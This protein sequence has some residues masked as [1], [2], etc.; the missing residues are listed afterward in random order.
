M[1][2]FLKEL[3]TFFEATT[4]HGL[5]YLSQ[6]HS[7]STRIIWTLIV[8]TAFG[9]ASYFLYETIKGFDTKYTSTTVED[10]S[11]HEYPFPA[12]T[13]DPNVYNSKIYFL[14]TF[15]NQFEFTAYKED[16]PKK[17]IN[18]QNNSIGLFLKCKN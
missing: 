11:I 15:L 3:F 7:R 5:S 4:I 10:R 13:F 8:F 1:N 6:N 2:N 12:V 17:M 16:N 9:I 14:R 18:S